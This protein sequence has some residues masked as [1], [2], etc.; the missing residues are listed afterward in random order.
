M[1]RV[2]VRCWL[3]QTHHRISMA[4]VDSGDKESSLDQDAA[5]VYGSSLLILPAQRCGGGWVPGAQLKQ[6]QR[7]RNI[8]GKKIHC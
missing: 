8:F 6:T 3:P 7:F 4:C 2:K 5:E 1:L